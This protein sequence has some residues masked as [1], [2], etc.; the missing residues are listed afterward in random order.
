MAASITP[1]FVQLPTDS[2]GK[3]IAAGTYTENA[4]VV[5]DQKVIPGEAY[6]PVYSVSAVAVAVST[7]NS[8]ILEIM[9]GSTLNV[10]IRRIVVTQFAP[11]ASTTAIPFQIWRVSTA[12]TGGSVITAQPYQT[13]DIAAGTT[14][15]TLASSKGTESV[16]LWQESIWLGTVAIPAPNNNLRWAQLD[17]SKPIVIQAG[18]SNGIAIKN[19]ASVATATIDVVVEFCETS[20]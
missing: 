7:S 19:T 14:A 20:Y 16:Q 18:T 3:K 12:G 8:H 17:F 13:T 1:S 10:R 2:V 6:L 15:M 11:P 9:A 4:S 5:Y